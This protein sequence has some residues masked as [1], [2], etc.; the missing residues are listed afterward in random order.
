LNSFQV[1]FD[2]IGELARRRHQTAERQFSA[3]GL[4][5]TEARL[6]SILGKAGGVAAQELLSSGLS[7]DRSNAGRA[8]QRLEH[9]GY[10]LRRKDS[11]DKRAKLVQITAKGGKAVVEISKLRK[12][13]AQTFFGELRPDEARVAAELLKK[14]L[15]SEPS[16]SE[17]SS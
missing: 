9:D 6:L 11:V 16:E 7:I 2:V 15:A 3:L 14:A 1:L 5:H 8:L 12:T 10:L 4:N 17:A 13:M